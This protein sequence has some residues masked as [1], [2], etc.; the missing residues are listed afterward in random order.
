MKLLMDAFNILLV[1]Q[2]KYKQYEKHMVPGFTILMFV[3]IKYNMEVNFQHP[4]T[5]IKQHSIIIPK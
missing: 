2:F 4:Y 5:H 1:T 3:L